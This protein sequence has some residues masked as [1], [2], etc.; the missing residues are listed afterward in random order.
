MVQIAYQRR[1]QSSLIIILH[2]NEI[3]HHVVVVSTQSKHIEMHQFPNSKS[4]NRKFLKPS[5]SSELLQPTKNQQKTKNGEKKP[6]ATFS[7][8]ICLLPTESVAL[9]FWQQTIQNGLFDLKPRDQGAEKGWRDH[10]GTTF[11]QNRPGFH[12]FW[13]SLVNSFVGKL[14]RDW[15]LNYD[16]QGHGNTGNIGCLKIRRFGGLDLLGKQ[17][18]NGIGIIADNG[19]NS[20][21]TPNS[22]TKKAVKFEK[23][24]LITPYVK[25]REN[26]QVTCCIELCCISKKIV[27]FIAPLYIPNQFY[28]KWPLGLQVN[29]ANTRFK[30]HVS[31]TLWDIVLIGSMGLAYLPTCIDC[32]KSTKR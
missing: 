27:A 19:R 15:L 32:N 26:W 14:I 22:R 3:C 17:G 13:G 9:D 20:L 2:R 29:L 11:E 16:S 30:Q 5:P 23:H 18:R 25:L 1:F 21:H 28:L 12:D 7:M 24:T 31:L 8:S 6:N 10:L 4:K